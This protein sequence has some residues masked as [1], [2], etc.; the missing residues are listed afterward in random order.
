MEN[1]VIKFR[2]L[3]PAGICVISG[4]DGDGEKYS[5]YTPTTTVT[6]RT[7]GDMAGQFWEIGIDYNKLH[8]INLPSEIPLELPAYI[9]ENESEEIKHE[10][11]ISHAKQAAENHALVSRTRKELAL[12]EEAGYIKVMSDSLMDKRVSKKDAEPAPI[13]PVVAKKKPGRPKKA[14]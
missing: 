13:A 5:T 10:Y 7:I 9:A 11:R 1:T 3:K 14:V 12:Y 6:P 8:A 4:K 2:F